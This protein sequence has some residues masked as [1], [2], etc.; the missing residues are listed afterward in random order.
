MKNLVEYWDPI[1]K[2]TLFVTKENPLPVT[3]ETEINVDITNPSINV[4]GSLIGNELAYATFPVTTDG[5]EVKV[6]SAALDHRHTVTIINDSTTVISVAVGT[7]TSFDSA[8]K[9]LSGRVVQLSL[10]TNVYTPIYVRTKYFDT[11]I[12]IIESA[13]V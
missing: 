10:N 7:N 13:E 2:R 9:L 4:T 6:G 11:N 5:V 8:I 1:Q 3:L 12:Q